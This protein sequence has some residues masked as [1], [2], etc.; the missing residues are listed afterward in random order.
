MSQQYSKALAGAVLAIAAYSSSASAAT[1][2]SFCNKTGS[3]V[4]VAIAHVPETTNKWTL[5][6]WHTVEAG[7]C[8]TIGNVR[9]GLFYYYAEKEGRKLHWPAAA[10]V[11]KNFCVP[12]VRVNREITGA[13]CPLGE[14]TVGFRGLT[15][16]AGKY[17]FTLN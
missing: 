9:T 10:Y 3:K 13:S 12:D 14:R 8:K 7:S 11:D 17:T 2:L 15:P 5:N 4:F 1:D 6:A 16:S